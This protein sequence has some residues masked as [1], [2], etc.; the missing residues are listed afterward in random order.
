MQVGGEQALDGPRVHERGED[1]QHDRD[2]DDPALGVK[3]DDQ[4]DEDDRAH[5]AEGADGS[6]APDSLCEDQQQRDEGNHHDDV[7]DDLPLSTEEHL[8][9]VILLDMSLFLSLAPVSSL[10]QGLSHVDRND[11]RNDAREEQGAPAPAGMQ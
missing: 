8:K 7:V 4:V 1:R 3:L 2:T 5:G 11:N 10:G 9:H 6:D